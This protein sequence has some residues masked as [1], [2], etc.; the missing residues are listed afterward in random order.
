MT[1][2][3]AGAG[4]RIVEITG[5]RPARPLLV[6]HPVYQYLA[7]RYGLNLRSVMWEPDEV[8]RETQWA[9]LKAILKDHPAKWMLW[10]RAPVE[11]SVERLRALA[12]KGWRWIPAVTDLR[13]VIS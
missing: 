1:G 7:R 12:L 11:E 13:R 4:Q 2:R 10:E 3:P 8:P 9:E 6:S 5:L